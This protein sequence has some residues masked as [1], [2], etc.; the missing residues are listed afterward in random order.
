MPI[1]MKSLLAYTLFFT[2]LLLASCGGAGSS[3]EENDTRAAVENVRVTSLEVREVARTIEITGTLLPWEERHIA[4][5]QPGRIMQIPVEIGTRVAQ[6]ALLVQMDP[7]QLLQAELQLSNL[8]TD[9]RRLD[10]LRKTGSI[11]KQQ[12]DQMKTQYEVTQR[13]VEFLRENTRLTAPFSGVISGKYNEPGEIFSAAP[14][15][16]T[17]KAA[18]V[19]IVQIDRLKV[20]VAVSEQYFPRINT[21]MNAVIL[22]DIYPDRPFTGS[23]FRIHPTID[24]ATRTFNIEVM[25]NNTGNLL[26]PGMF[27]RVQLDLDRVEALLI[28]AHAVLK[29]QGSNDRFLFKEENGNA[30]RVPVTLGR[31]YDDLVEVFSDKLNKG[32]RIVTSGQARLVDGA[33]VNIV[34]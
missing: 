7:T 13:N 20:T 9:F 3:E 22:T 4:P 28:P 31:R 24:P 23:V 33:A 12:F 29:M 30:V 27:C 18:I 11:A 25:L 19:S 1:T 26:R 14:N 17:G 5:A 34:Q 15:P 2:A 6:G 32:D 21:G 10:T 16:M 8:E